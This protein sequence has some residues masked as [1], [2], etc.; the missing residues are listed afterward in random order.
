MIGEDNSAS[1]VSASKGCNS[2]AISAA[3]KAAFGALMRQDKQVVQDQLSSL[4]ARVK[5]MGMS[6]APRFMG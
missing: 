5:S 6:S 4:V 1:L 3:I 2:D